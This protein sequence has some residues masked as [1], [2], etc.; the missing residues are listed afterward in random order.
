M[1][2]KPVIGLAEVTRVLEAARQ[3]ALA[4]QWP[5]TIVVVDDGGHPLALQRLD[6]CA[7]ASAY[8]AMEKARTSALGRKETRDYEDMVNR[9]RTAFVTAPLLT[10]LEG[11]VPLQVQ[12]Q[13]VGAI[14]VSGVKPDQDA[15]VA[16]AGAAAL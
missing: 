6:G 1:H 4:E 8:I 14:G 16:K 13:V 10:C 3:H 5:V 9:G 12:G 15:Q 2:S 7:P 11:G